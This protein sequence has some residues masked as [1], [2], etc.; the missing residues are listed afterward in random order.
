MKQIILFLL[1][2]LQ[3]QAQTNYKEVDVVAMAGTEYETLLTNV[4]YTEYDDFKV[5]KLLKDLGYN[6]STYL[7]PIKK[8]YDFT[9][10]YD[11]ENNSNESVF[12][13]F[14]VKNVNHTPITTKVEIYGDVRTIIRFYINFWST[15]LNFEDV[16]VGEVVSCR[17]LSDVATLSFPD[18]KTAKITVVSSKD[19]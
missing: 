15:D 6:T 3:F 12:A 7:Q 2:S 1:F 13:H 18:S 9:I 4:V 17:F 16:K 8:G 14:I 5:Y 19:R 11:K 10:Q